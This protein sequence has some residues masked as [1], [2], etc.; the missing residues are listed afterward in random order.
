M[1][2]LQKR[3]IK[4]NDKEIDIV[5][6]R[7]ELYTKIRDINHKSDVLIGKLSSNALKTYAENKNIHSSEE[8]MEDLGMNP[9]HEGNC[10]ITETIIDY[11]DVYDNN[12]IISCLI[13]DIQK[14]LDFISH[15]LNIKIDFMN[16]KP[17][18]DELLKLI[19]MEEHWL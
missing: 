5:Q 7:A 1:A 8:L 10:I 12:E 19:R 18:N 6:L 4:M 15:N 11:T 13:R 14:D 9:N 17:T 2:D 16:S 3:M